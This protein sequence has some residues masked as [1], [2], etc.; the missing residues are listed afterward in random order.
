MSEP[1]EWDIDYRPP[2]RRAFAPGNSRRRV[3]R[4][5]SAAADR[6]PVVCSDRRRSHDLPAALCLGTDTYGVR[7]G[8]RHVTERNA[9][10]DNRA[11]ILGAAALHSRLSGRLF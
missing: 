7:A 1:L 6:L 5:S 8:R 2:R 10:R 3:H 4:R 11:A 9:G